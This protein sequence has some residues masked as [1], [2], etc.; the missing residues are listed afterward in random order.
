[1]S[2]VLKSAIYISFLI[3][4]SGASGCPNYFANFANQDTDEARLFRAKM[5]LNDGLFTEAIDEINLTTADFQILEKVVVVKASALAGRCGLNALTFIQGIDAIG[6]GAGGRLF[7][8]LLSQFK[9]ADASRVQDCVDAENIVAGINTPD[10]RTNQQNL[11]LILIAFAKMGAILNKSADLDDDGIMDPA[12]D[13]CIA[14][15]M[16]DAD[17]D[18]FIISF[19]QIKENLTVARAGTNFGLDEVSSMDTAVCT[20]LGICGK[21]SAADIVAGD[22]IAMRGAIGTNQDLGLGSCLDTAAN[23][24]CP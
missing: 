13:Q 9:A 15:G 2:K 7:P 16:P 18:E 11:L 14:G 3:L 20:A 23:C 19:S 10:N 21:F 6:A 4:I 1:M 5:L 22:R 24:A 17:V 12:Y 8:Y